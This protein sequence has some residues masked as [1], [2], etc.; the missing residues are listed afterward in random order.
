MQCLAQTHH[1]K[2][3]VDEI[4]HDDHREMRLRPTTPIPV[5]SQADPQV[6]VVP[7]P[8]DIVLED[9]V[10]PLTL[11]LADFLRKFT[12]ERSV[13]PSNLFNHVVRK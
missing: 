1:L 4:T 9:D 13:N 8:L 2:V 6:T 10:G 7:D 3:S 5:A 12:V 11:A